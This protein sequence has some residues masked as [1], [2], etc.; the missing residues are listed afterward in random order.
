MFDFIP[1]DM[2]NKAYYY[3]A[4]ALFLTAILM[5]SFHVVIPDSTILIFHD[6]GFT[7]FDF[8]SSKAYKIIV[9]I[10]ATVPPT[11][12]L[13]AE[14]IT[15]KAITPTTLCAVLQLIYYKMNTFSL[16]S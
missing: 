4:V 12:G 5:F 6:P 11:M 15:Y 1:D 14:R 2:K 8:V 7:F 9:L 10:L 3:S 16:F 13:F